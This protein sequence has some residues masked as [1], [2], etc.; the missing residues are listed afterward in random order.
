MATSHLRHWS[1]GLTHS[2]QL[3]LSRSTKCKRLD[4][5]FFSTSCLRSSARSTSAHAHTS[6]SRPPSRVL[7]FLLDL[8]PSRPSLST[9]AASNPSTVWTRWYRAKNDALAT[10]ARLAAQRTSRKSSG[11]SFGSQNPFLNWCN[12]LPSN[13]IVWGILGLNGAVYMAWQYAAD[14]AVCI[15]QASSLHKLLGLTFCIN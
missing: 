3:F 10:R 6:I 4:T 14:Q 12:R 1:T 9:E 13:I 11:T 5:K 7:S 8:R 2:G 15:L